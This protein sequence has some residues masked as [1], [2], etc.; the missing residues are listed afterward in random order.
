MF[1]VVTAGPRGNKCK[2][3]EEKIKAPDV[4]LKHE[5]GFNRFSGHPVILKYCPKCGENV[6]KK[7]IS[8]LKEMMEVLKHGPSDSSQLGSRKIRSV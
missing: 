1:K 7:T 6:L 8:S 3:C 5:A 2:E 4:I